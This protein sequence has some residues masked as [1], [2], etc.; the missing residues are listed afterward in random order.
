MIKQIPLAVDF[1]KNI[2]GRQLIQEFGMA[3][4]SADKASDKDVFV[5]RD[6]GSRRTLDG[7][8]NIVWFHPRAVR[9]CPTVTRVVVVI[10]TI[11]L[12]TATAV[13]AR[14]LW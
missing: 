14:I 12:G 9:R 1:A 2:G 3:S 8:A 7:N 5:T 13:S 6:N 4:L 11:F 10:V